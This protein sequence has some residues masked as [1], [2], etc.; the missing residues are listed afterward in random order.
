MRKAFTLLLVFVVVS[1]AGLAQ[2][3]TV[4]VGNTTL[5]VRVV[6]QGTNENNGVDIPWEIIWG[7]DDYIWMTERYGRVSRLNPTTGARTTILDLTSNVYQSSESGLLGMVLHPDFENTPQVF[8]AYT[9]YSGGIKERIVRYEYN[10]NTEQLESPLTL[11]EGINGWTTHIGCRLLILPDNTLLATTGDYQNQSSP[12]NE[13]SLSGKILRMN[14]DGTIPTDNPYGSSS[15]L[16]SKGHRNAQGMVLAPNGL[17][18]SSEHG[19]GSND[20]LNIIE[21]GKNYGWPEVEGLCNQGWE[22]SWCNG[23][24]SYQDPIAIWYESST[25]ATS[26]LIWY[27]HPAI[28]EWQGKLLMAV[29]K[30]EHIKEI[31]VDNI[32]GTTVVS[33]HIWFNDSHANNPTSSFSNG[34]FNR[35]RDICAAPDGRVFIA[36]SGSSWSNN[37]EFSHSIIELKNSAYLP[38]SVEEFQNLETQI[39]PNPS[40]GMVNVIFDERLVGATYSVTDQ[41][42]RK[43]VEG[44]VLSGKMSVDFSGLASGLYIIQSSNDNYSTNQRLL[45]TE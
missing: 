26:D 7:P 13:S 38:I 36:T 16:Y 20:E 43:V 5:D 8:L 29:L 3:S 10:E 4:T 9:Y 30:A 37:N 33:Q 11:I 31:E 32:D 34:L 18:Y 17:L 40:T 12:Q 28:P 15:Y 1:L 14:L 44:P 35:L 41:L 27:D 24:T 23:V 25:I 2:P 45:L 19:P 39:Y 6:I 22:T 21:P 42:G